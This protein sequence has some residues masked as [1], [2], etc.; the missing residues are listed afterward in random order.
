M[1]ILDVEI[2][3]L[4][5]SSRLLLAVNGTHILLPGLPDNELSTQT[6]DFGC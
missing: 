5:D 6:S 1:N 3:Q 2:H 4:L